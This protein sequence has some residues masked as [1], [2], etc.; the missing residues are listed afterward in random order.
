MS[1]LSLK[2][3]FAWAL[4]YHLAVFTYFCVLIFL[5]GISKSCS[6]VGRELYN[7]CNLTKPAHLTLHG[8]KSTAARAYHSTSPICSLWEVP[9]CR[10]KRLCRKQLTAL[11]VGVL[12]PLLTALQACLNSHWQHDIVSLCVILFC[13]TDKEVKD[14]LRERWGEKEKEA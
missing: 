2:Y 4:S 11:A 3:S 7:Y 5:S 13:Y 6:G 10:R 8:I 9:C 1:W 12:K 14:K